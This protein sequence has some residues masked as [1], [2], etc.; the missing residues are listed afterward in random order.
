MGESGKVEVQ[1]DVAV[2]IGRKGPAMPG[3]E[4]QRDRAPAG[5]RCRRGTGSD[6][7]PVLLTATTF[8]LFASASKAGRNEAPAMSMVQEWVVDHAGL[9]GDLHVIGIEAD[10][11]RRQAVPIN[12]GGEVIVQGNAGEEKA[13][14]DK[15]EHS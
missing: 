13:L 8:T 9:V 4:L 2:E 6:A 5:C 7:C 12:R 10:I 14:Q 11:A 15:L 1:R 3:E